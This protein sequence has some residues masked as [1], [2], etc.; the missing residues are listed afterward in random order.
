MMLRRPRRASAT[1][2]VPLSIHAARA[3]FYDDYQFAKLSDA[4]LSTKVANRDHD[5]RFML[6]G[7]ITHS[8]YHAGQIALLRKSSR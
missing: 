3:A 2:I 6:N 4:Q 5:Y 1:S 7:A 8:V